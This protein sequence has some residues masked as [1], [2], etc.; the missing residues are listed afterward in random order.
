MSRLKRAMG[1][2]FAVL[3]TCALPIMAQ[4]ERGTISGTVRDPSGATV[5]DA[6]VVVTNSGTG[7]AENT[8]TNQNGEY[9]TPNL[10]PG[11][12]SIKV[13][14]A[15]FST[16]DR[17]GVELHVNERVTADLTLT[18]GEVNQQIEVQASAPLLESES[19]TVDNVITRREVAELPLNG[20]SIYQL[21]YLNAGVTAAIPTQNA[22]NTSIPDNARA[23]QGLS[24]NGQRQS[25][26]TF[27]L[28]GVYNN[29]INQGLSAILP[30][31]EA[32]QEF[33]VETS[34]FM[35]EIGRGG[36]VVNVTLKSGTNGVHGN[37][38]EF[39]RNSALDARN[40]FDY[41]SPRRLP[42]FVQNQFGG[43]VGGPIVKNHTFFFVD[44][45]GFRQRQGQSFV[46][47]VPDSNVRTGNFAG[48]DREI[49]DPATYN[50]I[51]N[52][53]MPFPDQIIPQSRFN[54]AALNVLKYFP[55]G[56]TATALDTGEQF[57]YS[58]A[59]RSNNQDS[60]DIKIDQNFGSKDQLTGRYS[61][62]NSHTVLPGAFSDL[63]Q[64]APAIGGALT[65][66]G[67]GLLTG[68][69]SNP[70]RSLGI[71]EIH[72]FNPTTINEFRVA[73]VRCGSDAVQLNYGKTYASQLG[74]P[75]VN[76]TADNSGFPQIGITGFSTLGDT[77]FFPLVELENVFQWLD[78]VTFVRGSHTYKAG[79]DIKR[80]QRNFTQILGAPAGS[81]SFGPNF[82]ADPTNPDVTGNAF[83]DFLLGIPT[84][85]SIVTTSG[86]AGIRSTEASG[87]FQ[88]TWKLTQK[89]TLSYGLRYDLFTP[90]TEV[91]NRQ[92]N[93]DPITGKLVLPGQ[94]GSYPGLST[95]ALVST[96]K[97]N[98]APR[99]GF[100]YRLGDKTVV[101]S[102]YGIFFFP[103]SQAGQQMTLNPPW[104]GGANY[105]NT[106]EP[107][108][109]VR[110]L[111][112]GLPPSSGLIPIDDP[113][114]AFN[115]RFPANHTAYVQQWSFGIQ[116]QL[117]SSWLVEVNYVGN[118]SVHLQD[119]Y[120]LNQ[121]YP[122]TGNVQARRPFYAE[123]PNLTDFTYVEQRGV[124]DYEGLQL[125]IK[126]RFTKGFT[127][128]SD[129][130]YS[131]AI[132][133]PGSNYGDTG[134]QNA[135]DLD[136]DRSLA[137]VDLRNRWVSSLLY[138][139]PFGRGKAFG[140]NATGVAN[141]IIGGWQLG[142]VST[143]QSGLPF[144]VSGGAG[145][146]D[147][148]CNG[149]TPPGGHT[150]TEWFDTS[151]F[152]LPAVVADPVHGGVYVPFGDAGANILIGPGLVSLDLSAFK[153]FL[154][155]ETKRL[156]FRSEWFNSLNRANFMAPSA[157]VGTGTFGEILNA[158]PSRQI[159][160]VLKFIF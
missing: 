133:N 95:D 105:T 5:A 92:T 61:F 64:F 38:F 110:T 132:E 14:A 101:R 42:N 63:P 88:D 117:T 37:A 36:G 112:M 124:G 73:Y 48:T 17:A 35:P 28:D 59:S 52:T 91:F 142:A 155:T 130:T 10:I 150:V 26:N 116:H 53:R 153:S 33:V 85:A 136:A 93:I 128:L 127:F 140:G 87:Y 51:T 46:A 129:Y 145:R 62:G 84:S 75:N 107:Q 82:T 2:L 89:L 157:T 25:N 113:S 34:N 90:Q 114:G 44:Y 58:G 16:L 122:G 74:I 32:V 146:P 94:G 24:V 29:Q 81:F 137:G 158:G 49:F 80:I 45:Q 108:Q 131:K 100:A 111:D 104:V 57:F 60:F 54:P 3:L 72:N 69:V 97:H 76:I 79:V 125:S 50:S 121:P 8:K 12:Y 13:S 118:I 86:L 151:C 66:A 160:M 27:I 96:N 43:S 103:E 149:Q 21:A 148:I 109:I 55:A 144:T 152:P 9:V 135:R 159:Q 7:V 20:R 19:S 123:D 15:G 139:L 11:I 143:V 98:F 70:A 41:T 99:F 4:V 65:T 68:L 115:G 1:P 18:V 154:M 102:S 83:A 40:F 71:Q 147:R 22:N 77:A 67:A 120:N 119:Q 31:L 134:H 30:P 56:T 138:E 39:L 47:T 141:Q 126:K 6:N 156:E 23:E 78:N 106:P